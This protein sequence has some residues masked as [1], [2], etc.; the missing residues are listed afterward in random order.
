MG[1]AYGGK[2]SAAT[3]ENRMHTLAHT[4]THIRTHTHI[5]RRIKVSASS[6]WLQRHRSVVSL[7]LQQRRQR[8]QR[9]ASLADRGSGGAGTPVGGVRPALE[10]GLDPS[11]NWMRVQNAMHFLT[12]RRE[13]QMQMQMQR[14]GKHTHTHRQTYTHTQT[15]TCNSHSLLCLEL[16]LGAAYVGNVFVIYF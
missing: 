3:T 9:A 16:S 8:R 1:G 11:R 14:G 13:M 12:Q 4:H 2:E 5:N 15:Y 10:P 6:I 7:Q